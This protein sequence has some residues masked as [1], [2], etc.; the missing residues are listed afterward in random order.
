MQLITA[1]A[2]KDAATAKQYFGE[3]FA[4]ADYY[5]EGQRSVLQWFGKGVERLGISPVSEVAQEAFHRLCDN[6]HPV[7]GETLTSRRRQKDRRVCYDFTVSAPKSVSILAL[8][9]RD[10]RLLKAHEESAAIAMALMES[11][12]GTRVRK[13]GGNVDRRTGEVVGVQVT[14][15][16]SR[17][18]DPQL[19]THFVIF[20]ATW[21]ATENRWKAL[22][23]HEMYERSAF[24][25]E[26]YRNELARRVKAL[27][28]EIREAKHGF[29]IVGV[30]PEILERFSKRRRAVLEAEAKVVKKVGH[31]L[32]NN[33]RATLAHSTREWKELGQDPAQILGYQRSQLTPEELAA[34]EALVAR[35]KKP[36]AVDKGSTVSQ[37]P[38]VASVPEVTPQ[39]A[40]HHALEHVFERR[41]VV[42]VH[43]ILQ[44]ALSYSRGDVTLEALEL[45]LSRY[46]GLV[47][48]NGRITTERMVQKERELIGLANAGLGRQ[49][50]LNR[51]LPEDLAVGKNQRAAYQQVM[52]SPDGVVLLRGAAGSGKSEVLHGIHRALLEAG[53]T[54]LV[55]APTCAA[56]DALNRPGMPR[57]TTTQGFLASPEG[58][59]RVRGGVMLVDEAGLL[60]LND[61]HTLLGVAQ[62]EGAR[63]VL[64]GDTRQ[65][66]GIEA[67]DALRLLEERSA[68]QPIEL[69]GIRRQSRGVYREA[70]EAFSAGHGNEALERLESIGAL[71]E[72]PPEDRYGKLV[73]R[74]VDSLAA[75]KSALIVSPTWQEIETVTEEV[76]RGLQAA[77]RLGQKETMVGVHEPQNWTRAQK[78]DWKSYSGELVLNFHRSTAVVQRGTS[79][80]VDRVDGDGVIG[81]DA[82][83]LE[84]RI[85]RKQVA[86][87]EVA[88]VREIPVAEGETLLIRG[89]RREAGVVNGSVVTVRAL[90]ENGAIELTDGR[91]LPPDFRSFTHGYC[92]TSHTAQGRTVD[93]VY[94]AMGANSMMATNRNQFY[95]STS[96]GRERVEIFTHDVEE[97]R[98]MVR[99]SGDRKGAL[100]FLESMPPK[101]REILQP[102]VGL[103]I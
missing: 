70:I 31:A 42:P 24:V 55:L 82:T 40:I 78:C 76:R 65:H 93:H 49:R 1:H 62:R 63:V 26:V 59:G 34:L 84:V 51:P 103:G 29:E 64:C 100:E 36:K 66:A 2:Q 53:Q 85:T 90:R 3:H 60:S 68:L 22:Q 87:F 19:H 35:S 89:N 52:Q 56:C 30:T 81:L 17:S 54:V 37:S 14:H 74:Y 27:G 86:C 94:V 43:L 18:L 44:H 91:V 71:H 57:A 73:D 96:R 10:L 41:S 23:V 72:T 25:T 92:V 9:F 77:G 50:P 6:L 5:S 16:A 98:A 21:D 47:A 101:H 20:N 69:N 39:E 97:L 88:R 38:A 15:G 67:G 83:G 58:Q 80:T 12:A 102:T 95:V 61:M 45:C 33:A 75:E 4:Q 32:S 48:S 8:V 99:R 7:T 46:P 28:Y 79:L 13:G 11:L